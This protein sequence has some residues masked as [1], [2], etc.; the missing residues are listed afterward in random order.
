MDKFMIDKYVFRE[1][2]QQ[3]PKQEQNI[4]PIENLENNHFEEVPY[5][6][7]SFNYRFYVLIFL[8][9]TG[10]IIAIYYVIKYISSKSNYIIKQNASMKI[11]ISL[12]EF[13]QDVKDYL[14]TMYERV[15]DWKENLSRNSSFLKSRED[16]GVFK[17]TKHRAKNLIKSA[18]K[19]VPVDEIKPDAEEIIVKKN[20]NI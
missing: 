12:D 8:F 15:M 20:E 1:L 11:D 9:I 19:P 13:K 7:K 3:E 4:E 14:R 5:I 2:Q 10:I 16:Y 6:E 17:A 18:V